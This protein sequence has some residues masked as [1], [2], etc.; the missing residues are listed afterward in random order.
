M[1]QIPTIETFYFAGLWKY[2]NVSL[3]LKKTFSILTKNASNLI[4]DI[5]SRMPVILNIEEATKYI[6]NYDYLLESSFIS[7]SEEELDFFPVSRLVNSPQ[8]NSLRCI[9]PL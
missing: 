9:E 2:L 8:N 3:S 7:K 1:I 6:N 4:N 5:H